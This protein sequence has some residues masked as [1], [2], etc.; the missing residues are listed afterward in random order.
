[1]GFQHTFYLKRH[2]ELCEDD[3]YDGPK[4]KWIAGC[5]DFAKTIKYFGTDIG[6]DKV[7]FTPFQLLKL[8]MDISSDVAGQ[9]YIFSDAY[10]DYCE[11]VKY[12]EDSR[13]EE[14]MLD[15]YSILRTADRAL[16]DCPAR[17]VKDL[18]SVDKMKI[19]ISNLESLV[20]E[21]KEDDVVI[22]ELGY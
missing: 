3:A 14:K 16:S 13:P 15:S 19:L 4:E 18:E 5:R 11:N 20:S 21:M 7:S 22:W 1:M 17:N 10:D 2:S 9:W 12:N 6:S 8:I